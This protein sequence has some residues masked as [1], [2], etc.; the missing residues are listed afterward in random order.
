MLYSVSRSSGSRPALRTSLLICAV[1]IPVSVRSVDERGFA[2]VK[3]LHEAQ[4]TS[5]LRTLE[6]LKGIVRDQYLLLRLDEA[7]AVAAIPKLLP[8]D[9]D[10]RART[11]R[12]IQRLA[13]APGKQSE[14]GKLRLA[15]IEKL[16]G[17][18]AGE[19]K[20]RADAR[21]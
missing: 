2:M 10:E 16:F 15:K 19:S 6:E 13:L 21:S 12:A 4:P 1:D 8:R 14:E 17:T 9:P 3:Q 18:A 20:E 7:R 5:R 11:L